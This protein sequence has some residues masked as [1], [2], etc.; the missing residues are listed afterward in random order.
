MCCLKQALPLAICCCIAKI[1]T[2]RWRVYL[3]LLKGREGQEEIE[4]TAILH[5]YIGM[6][7]PKRKITKTAEKYI[8]EAVRIRKKIGNELR[9]NYSYFSL[10]RLLYQNR[11]G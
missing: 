11:P 5:N 6:I 8:N 1:T 2:R 10:A 9:L 7:I 3:Q 4:Q